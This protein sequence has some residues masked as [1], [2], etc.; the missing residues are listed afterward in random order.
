M[1][2]LKVPFICV[3]L[4]IFGGMS[5]WCDGDWCDETKGHKVMQWVDIC[6]VTPVL[7]PVPLTLLLHTSQEVHASHP[8]F[9]ISQFH[10]T[11]LQ[12]NNPP[13]PHPTAHPPNSGAFSF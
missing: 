7:P 12:I 11:R 1:T 4:V 13:P 10:Q 5:G 3:K 6:V 8:D 2:F 9:E